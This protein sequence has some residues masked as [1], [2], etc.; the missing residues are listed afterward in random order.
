MIGYLDPDI[1]NQCFGEYPNPLFKMDDNFIKEP[2]KNLKMSR[3]L[4]GTF[5]LALK[6]SKYAGL[7]ARL[8]FLGFTQGGILAPKPIKRTNVQ[9]CTNAH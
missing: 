6:Q 3:K 7:T 8:T 9:P 5:Y 4:T 2:Y 1:V